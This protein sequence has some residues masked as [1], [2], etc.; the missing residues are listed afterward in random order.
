MQI[1]SFRH[2]IQDGT[3]YLNILKTFLPFYEEFKGCKPSSSSRYQCEQ[4]LQIR[5][6]YGHL[7]IK[8]PRNTADSF[9]YSTEHNKQERYCDQ[10][11][12][13]FHC[14]PQCCYTCQPQSTQ[15]H[16]T[17]GFSSDF[18][19]HMC[20]ALKVTV[21]YLSTLGNSVLRFEVTGN[22]LETIN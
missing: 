17:I 12:D 4:N 5:F 14:P 16:N 15:C 20:T 2:T 11:A 8:L 3:Q 22:K 13:N 19:L 7:R 18:I 6:S 10:N 9:R 21:H 1:I